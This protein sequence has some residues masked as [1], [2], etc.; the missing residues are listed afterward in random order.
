MGSR[1][2]LHDLLLSIAGPNVY[3][4]APSNLTI[5]YPA[6]KY[7]RDKIENTHADDVVY[8]QKTRYSVIVMSKV[9]DDKIVDDISK[10]SRCSFDRAYIQDG[11]HH[12][13]FNL[14]Y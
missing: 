7:S 12:N 10:L 14:Y 9:V 4:Q 13:I 8:N 3:Y 6:I 11:I 2:G 5:K 1:L